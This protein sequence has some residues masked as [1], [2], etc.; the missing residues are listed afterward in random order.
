MLQNQVIPLTYQGAALTLPTL[1]LFGY[2]ASKE[3]ER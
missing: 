1:I 3:V 2:P